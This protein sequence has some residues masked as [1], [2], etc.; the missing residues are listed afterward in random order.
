MPT[1]GPMSREAVL[2]G[3]PIDCIGAPTRDGAAFGSEL[4]PAALRA[5]GVVEAVGAVDDG[6]LGCG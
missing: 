5:S 1:M 4:A 6:D 2:I 3:V